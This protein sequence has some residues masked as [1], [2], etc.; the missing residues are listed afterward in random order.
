[1]ILATIDSSLV[2]RGGLGE[3]EGDTTARQSPVDFRVGIKAVVDATTLLFVKDNLESL[4][5]VLLGS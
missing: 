5:A 1:M 2:L 3:L 4:V